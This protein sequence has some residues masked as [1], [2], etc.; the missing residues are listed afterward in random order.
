MKHKITFKISREDDGYTASSSGKNY[1]IVTEGD[2]FEDLVKNIKEAVS[3]YLE[4][5]EFDFNSK[6]VEVFGVF[7]F[8][9]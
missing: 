1:G 3:L 9:I 6:D 2:T 5:D 4:D 8:T 7:E